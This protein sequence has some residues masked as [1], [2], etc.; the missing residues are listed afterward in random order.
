MKKPFF[1][2][3]LFIFVDSHTAGAA[4]VASPSAGQG[5]QFTAAPYL[6]AA[7]VHGDQA[8]FGGPEVDVDEGFT[9]LLKTLDVGFMGA[10]EARSERV[11]L[12]GDLIW[13]KASDHAKLPLG[14]SADLDTQSWI[15][16]GL[17]GYSLIYEERGNFDIVAGA[18]LWAIDTD[19]QLTTD[20]LGKVN[21]QGNEMWVDPV[22]GLHGR[23]EV[24][25]RLFVTGFG[26]VGGFGAGSDFM[27]DAFGGLGY[28]FNDRLSSVIGFRGFGV[29]YKNGAFV[30]DI[31]QAGP[32]LGGEVRF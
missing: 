25:D 4:D 16:T 7:G 18:R 29:D 1:L 22:V 24:T 20:L 15:V 30:Y 28:H 14:G 3:L 12:T 31:T 8:L 10:F 9:D 27:W 23:Y 13:A 2:L 26:L 32:V 21:L 19:L 11:S 17:A 6:W 5:W